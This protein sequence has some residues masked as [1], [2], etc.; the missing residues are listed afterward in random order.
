LPH[1]AKTIGLATPVIASAG[2]V[3]IE[4][5]GKDW[6][7]YRKAQLEI[8]RSVT[9]N[10]YGATD[11]LNTA[12]SEMQYKQAL[13][14]WILNT[15]P[16]EGWEHWL[17]TYDLAGI[18]LL[19]IA[20]CREA[21]G[22]VPPPMLELEAEVVPKPEF[23]DQMSVTEQYAQE[24]ENSLDT[25]WFAQW[26]KRS[27]IVCGESSDGKSFLLVN[28]VLAGFLKEYGDRCSVYICDPDY[29]S[30]HGDTQPNTW[31][32]LPV[33]KVVY[34][35]IPDIYKCIMHVSKI[36]DKR[37]EMTTEAVQAK[38][39]KPTFDPVLLIVDEEPFAVSQMEEGMVEN[40]VMA[41]ANILRRGLKQNVTFK[42]GTQALAVGGKGKSGTRLNMDLLRQVEMVILYRAAQVQEN[43]SNLGV[44]PG[45]VQDVLKQLLPLPKMLGTKRV[46]VTYLDKQ[47]QIAGVP[48]VKPVQVE[49]SPNLSQPPIDYSKDDEPEDDV[50]T[51]PTASNPK[52]QEPAKPDYGSFPEFCKAMSDRLPDP[53]TDTQLMSLY[54]EMSDKKVAQK[55]WD[56]V[57]KMLREAIEAIR[58][59]K[60]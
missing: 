34:T 13:K 10:Q 53:F 14:D 47:L 16:I 45:V 33:G 46:C 23:N 1:W 17:K 12:A 21:M 29:G 24:V 27:G 37:A 41:I 15:V 26:G 42:M 11:A 48:T 49:E 59:G 20:A 2:L 50:K 22:L 6:K 52:P 31:L 19:E 58:N 56:T 57:A 25:S 40:F 28:I 35:K 51:A 8:A 36:V 32:D 9:E 55:N 5:A 30:S 38:Q 54:L 7:R 39:P 3:A 18:S 60:K 43:Y 4:G 44:R